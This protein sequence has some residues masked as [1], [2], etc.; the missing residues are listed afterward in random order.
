VIVKTY[1]DDETYGVWARRAH[2][3]GTTVAA[4][5]AAAAKR[6]VKKPARPKRRYVRVTVEMRHQIA[7]LHRTGLGPIAIAYE[8]GCSVASVYNHLPKEQG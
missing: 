4:L 7:D 8:V 3:E 2:A 1:L 6:A 5:L